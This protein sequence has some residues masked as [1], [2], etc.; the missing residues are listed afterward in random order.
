MDQDAVREHLLYLL[1]GGGAHPSFDQVL[2]DLPAE[3]RG[4]KPSG[5]SQTPWRLLE[6]LRTRPTAGSPG[7]RPRE[8]PPG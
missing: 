4:Q 8:R 1:S 6:H 3:L 2:A 7:R 5:L